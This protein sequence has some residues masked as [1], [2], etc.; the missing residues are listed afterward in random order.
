MKIKS[1]ESLLT[2]LKEREIKES[3]LDLNGSITKAKEELLDKISQIYNIKL[4]EVKIK[5]SEIKIE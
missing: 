5:Y 2:E 3:N 4:S 1:L